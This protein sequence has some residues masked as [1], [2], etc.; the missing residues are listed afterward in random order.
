MFYMCR[1]IFN[2]M[3]H[4]RYISAGHDSRLSSQSG[5]FNHLT[6]FDVIHGGGGGGMR[7][8]S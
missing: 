4:I 2:I 5:M 8:A 1:D 7:G 6:L 3:V